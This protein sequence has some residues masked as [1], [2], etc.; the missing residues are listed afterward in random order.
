MLGNKEMTKNKM[1]RTRKEGRKSAGE[2]KE[3]WWK[4]EEIAAGAEDRA[5]DGP[6]GIVLS[7]KSISQDVHIVKPIHIAAENGLKVSRRQ[8]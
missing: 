8:C 1:G 7:G 6:Q 3:Q 4:G 2:R 5:L